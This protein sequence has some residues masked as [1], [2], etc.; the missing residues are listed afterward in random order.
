M[1]QNNAS[2]EHSHLACFLL[3]VLSHSWRNA[4]DISPRN[5]SYPATLFPTVNLM[6]FTVHRVF[7]KPIRYFKYTFVPIY[8]SCSIQISLAF[9]R[10]WDDVLFWNC[11]RS[12]RGGRPGFKCT[13]AASILFPV[14]NPNRHHRCTF[15]SDFVDSSPSLNPMPNPLRDV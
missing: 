6:N 11:G 1:H 2:K 8:N 13:D 7:Y 4:I 14:D 12:T 3:A 10:M 9:E 5:L 15:L